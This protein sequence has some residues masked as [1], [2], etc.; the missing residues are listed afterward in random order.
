MSELAKTEDVE[1]LLA[2]AHLERFPGV[3]PLVARSLCAAET[4]HPDEARVLLDAAAAQ[5]P[6][7]EKDSEWLPMLAQVAEAIAIIGPTPSPGGPARA[8]S[9][10]ARSSWS[11]AS[12]PSSE[13]RWSVTSASSPPPSGAER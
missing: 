7:A 9:P 12:A 8:C 3:W 11:K 2:D 13:A 6:A 1:A 5:L 4:A 10:T